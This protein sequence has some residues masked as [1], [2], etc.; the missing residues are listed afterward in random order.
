M[1]GIFKKVAG[2][3]SSEQKSS[4]CCSSNDEQ[5][6]KFTAAPKK[7]VSC[8]SSNNGK[9]VIKILGTGCANCVT[10]KNRVESVI[11]ELDGEFEV[12][13]VEDI[14]EIMKYQVI[15]TPGLV[16]NEEVKSAGK[17]LSIEDIKK[18]INS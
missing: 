9:I 12:I 10:L 6:A 11:N 4:C 7:E 2:L 3:F 16:V 13:K 18:I 14:Q 8:C 17:L 1:A 5:I 15:S